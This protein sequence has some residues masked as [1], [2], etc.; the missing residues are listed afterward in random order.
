MDTTYS[1]EGTKERARREDR[2]HERLFPCGERKVDREMGSIKGPSGVRFIGVHLDEEGH[3]EDT[4]H[5]TSVVSEE[6][7]TKGG[8]DTHEVGLHRH[9]SLNPRRIGRSEHNSTSGHRGR[10]R[11]GGV[12][13]KGVWGWGH[14]KS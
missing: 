10:I 9:R 5:P 4:P 2:G 13:G 14:E 11:G 1:N 8:E 12:S 3:A 7:T 6:N